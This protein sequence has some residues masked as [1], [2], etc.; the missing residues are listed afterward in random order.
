M[1]LTFA[2]VLRVTMLPITDD[3]F[4]PQ[5]GVLMRINQPCQV[6]INGKAQHLSGPAAGPLVPSQGP[7]S[8]GRG[9]SGRAVLATGIVGHGVVKEVTLGV[10]VEMRLG[11]VEGRGRSVPGAQTHGWRGGTLA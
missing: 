9:R 7:L 6:E 8:A 1:S 2:Q 3:N 11:A 4:I 5:V 10:R